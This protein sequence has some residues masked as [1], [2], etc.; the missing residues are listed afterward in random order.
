MKQ[1]QNEIWTILSEQTEQIEKES[2]E[3]PLFVQ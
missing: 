1:K 2:I 3:I